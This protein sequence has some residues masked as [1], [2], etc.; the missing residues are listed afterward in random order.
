MAILVKKNSEYGIQ[1]TEWKEYFCILRQ[2]GLPGDLKRKGRVLVLMLAL[3]AGGAAQAQIVKDFVD[4]DGARPNLLHGF[5]VVSGLNNTGDDPKGPAG[6]LI[7]NYFANA[8]GQPL[9]RDIGSKNY[10]MVNVEAELPPFQKPGTKIDVRV[11]AL[12]AKSLAGGTLLITPLRSPKARD[13]DPR[14]FALAQGRIVLDNPTAGRVP[15]GAIVETDLEHSFVTEAAWPQLREI[16]AGVYADV[17]LSAKVVKLLLK[18]PDFTLASIVAQAVNEE[19]SRH[20]GHTSG[21]WQ[22]GMPTFA[23]AIDGGTVLVRVPAEGDYLRPGEYAG[24]DRDPVRFLERLVLNTSLA[25]QARP[26]Q[27]Q[28]MISDSMKLI[29]VIGEVKVLPGHVQAAVGTRSL[30]IQ[31]PS[32]ISLSDFLNRDETKALTP[33]QIMDVVKQMA[34]IGLIK[35]EV[36][37]Q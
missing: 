10:A 34:A 24:Y 27:A 13:E 23:R 9:P 6:I 29:A 30:A 15:G 25:F 32:E 21:D 2:V 4:V 19:L 36:K 17:G 35:G 7:A 12:G 16:K 11:S 8:M 37:S 3:A 18:R 5:G 1:E 22:K 33:Q 20:L 31:I 26:E 14:V 28:V